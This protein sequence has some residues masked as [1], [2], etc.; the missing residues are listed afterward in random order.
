MQMKKLLAISLLFLTFPVAKADYN[1]AN[2]G[3]AA[4]MKTGNRN[5]STSTDAPFFNPAGAV[6]GVDGFTVEFSTIP[7]SSTKSVFD[8]G[9][10][11][12]KNNE[13]QSKTSSLFYPALNLTYK[14]DRLAV[15]MFVGIT[16]GGGAGNYDD[17]LPKFE[18][19]GYFNV[20]SAIMLGELP[21]S[22][23]DY[24]VNS[25]FKGSAYGIGT[26]IG[27][28]YRLNDWASVS[29]AFQYSRQMNH[30]EGWLD[31]T[32][33]PNPSS[34]PIPR[35][36]IDVDFTGQNFGVIAGLNLKP[37]PNL[38]IAQTF[39]YYTELT[40]DTKVNDSKD[41]GLFTNGEKVK[42]TYVPTY[43]VGIAYN[44]SEKLRVDYNMN[45][46][47]YSLLTLDEDESGVNIADYYNNGIDFGIAAEY[48]ISN[49]LNW[50][51]G[52]T[53]APSKMKKEYQNEVEFENNSLWLNTGLGIK[54]K[55]NLGIDLGFQLGLAT[56]EGGQE[57]INLGV[58]PPFDQTY[59]NGPSYSMGIGFWYRF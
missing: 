46:S 45:F 55:E 17:G 47:F 6:W 56:E 26:S 34:V 11:L 14:K 7:F 35:T 25:S 4:K 29:G 59:K 8:N 31:I 9:N 16:N 54:V 50:G 19:L 12:G 2:N 40:L 22:V 43:N 49:S 37:L 39:R 5:A 21:G 58:F 20:M 27:V 51:V 36:E 24:S 32:Y 30:Q 44:V 41:G 3:S 15:T 33:N 48:E 18:R 13:Y 52:F 38:L 53:Y 1:P 42:S 10:F 57:D 28:A 23:T